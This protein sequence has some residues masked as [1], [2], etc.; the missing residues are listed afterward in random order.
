[1][2]RFVTPIL[3]PVIIRQWGMVGAI[4]VAMATVEDGG[5]WTEKTTPSQRAVKV[6]RDSW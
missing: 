6:L 3:E 4:E 2:D 1:L 5:W